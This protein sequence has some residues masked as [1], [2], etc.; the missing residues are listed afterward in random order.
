MIRRRGVAMEENRASRRID[1]NG[2][3]QGVGFRP[4]VYQLANRRKLKGEVANTSSGV[5]I[6]LEGPEAEIESFLIDLEK[7]PPPLAQITDIAV[8]EETWKGFPDFSIVHS[9][10]NETRSTLISP[11]MCVCDDCLR[12]LFDPNDRRYRYPFVNCTNCGPRYTIIEDIPYDR[13]KTSMKNFKMCVRCREEYDDPGD[14]RFHAQPNACPECGPQVALFDNA[15]A[16]I[17]CEDPAKETARLLLSG[18]IVAVKGLGGFHL[19]A[20]ARN[21][22][23]VRTLRRRKHREEKPLAIMVPNIDG[24][25]AFALMT[26]EDE[27]LLKNP[28][29]PIVILEKKTPNDISVHVAPGNGNF[30]VVLPY[31]P[32]HYLLSKETDA[33]LVMTSGNVSEEPICIDNG[34]AFE[35]LSGIADFFL[36]HDRDILLRSDDSIVRRMAGETRM[37][38]RSR[39]YVPVPIFLGR[40]YP[41]VLACGAELKNTVCLIKDDKAFLSQHIGDLENLSALDF[42]KTTISHM[43]R[44]LDIEPELIACDMHPDYLSTRYALEQS[45]LPVIQVQHHHAHIVS[46]LAENRIDGPVIGLAFD[47][48]GYG[49]DGAVWGGEVLISDRMNFARAARL[50]Y[51]AM[52]GAAAAVKEP[53]RMALAYLHHA[54][55]K[56]FENLDIP[57]VR[58]MDKSKAWIIVRMIERKI[59]SPMTSSMG[60]LFDGVAAMLGVREKVAFE[61]QAA[62]E[63]EA[64]AEWPMEEHY[65]FEWTSGDCRIISVAPIIKGVA[66]DMENGLGTAKISGKFHRTLARMFSSLCEEIRAESG[67][68]TVALSGG[69]FQNNILL[70]GLLEELGKSGFHAVAQRT[71]P[72]NDGGIALGQAVSAAARFR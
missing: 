38:R 42:F 60:R 29:R 58:K 52:P 18:H 35:R 3:V 6:R 55:G 11:D 51:V 9:Q 27:K 67:I 43:K 62:M 69:S 41:Q 23:A 61:G 17:P 19:A 59:N 50:D 5:V 15:G 12:E 28:R 72:C 68:D 70:T 32:L 22:E 63:L 8:A 39:G 16:R 1:V 40:K 7:K 34:E 26:D 65:D 48:T 54:F 31:T 46:C 64:A 56:D 66:A 53:Y 14:R 44:I 57:F 37:I 49:I 36:V 25:R 30:G 20:D 13:P 47:G 24:V 10:G 71:A 45:E 21:D 4:F 2:I 33:P